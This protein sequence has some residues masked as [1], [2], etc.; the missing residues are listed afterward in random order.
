MKV[1]EAGIDRIIRVI[2]G[3]ALLAAAY[4]SLD[5]TWAIVAYVVGAVL[6]VT[7]AVGVCP[8]YAIFGLSTCPLKK[9]AN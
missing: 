8:A 3:I 1:N 5:G 4:L 2:V 7:G 9:S 6:F